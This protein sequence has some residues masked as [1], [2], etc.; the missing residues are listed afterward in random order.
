ME[1]GE[2]KEGPKGLS[3]EMMVGIGK[4]WWVEL[5]LGILWIIAA[6]IILQFK[7]SSITTIGIIIGIM[8]LVAGLQQFMIA[9]LSEGWKW[10][11]ILFG[12]LFITSGIVALVYPKDTFKAVADVIGFLFLVFGFFWTME[13]FAMKETNELWWLTLVS[14]I[15]MII[16]GFWAAGQFFM[17]KAYTLLV[18]VGIW[19]L[20]KGFNDIVMAFM[21]RHMGK[22]AAA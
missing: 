20:F 1:S 13:A 15:L 16:L 4:F 3:R 9:A 22:E 21:M 10:L 14:G 6:M 12:I 7:E 11:W 2:M 18:F 8:F 5:G 19:A 17:T